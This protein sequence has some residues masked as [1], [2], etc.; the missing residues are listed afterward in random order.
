MS[1]AQQIRMKKEHLSLSNIQQ[2]S[3]QC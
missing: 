3:F 1:E 2:Y